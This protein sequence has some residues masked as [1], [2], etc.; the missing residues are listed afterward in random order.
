[1]IDLNK[2]GDFFILDLANNHQGDLDHA[3]KIIDAFGKK[4]ESFEI[5]ATIKLQFRNL[6]SYIHKSINSSSSDNS[7]VKRF[8]STKLNKSDYSKIINKIKSYNLKTMSTPFDEDSFSLINELDID[9]IKI[10]SASANDKSLLLETKK[11]NKPCVISVGGK[12]IE[13]ID[14]IVN[15]FENYTSNFILQHC[16]AVYPT[17]DEDLELNQISFLKNRYP[18]IKIGYSTHEDPNNLDPIK[19]A[20]S[21]G[22]RSFERHIGIETD[23]YKLNG[24]S[25]NLKQFE[26]WIISYQDAKK[27]L[28]ASNKKPISNKENETLDSLSRGVYAKQDIENQNILTSKNTYFSFPL[29][30]KQLS[31]NNFEDFKFITSKIIKKDEPILIDRIK[32]NID[33]ENEIKIKS[34]MLQF[35]SMLKKSKTYINKDA[36]IELSHHYG[37]DKFREF[38][39]LIITCFNYDYAKKLILLL[40]RQKHPYHFHKKKEETF[41][42]LYGDLEAEIDGDPLKLSNGDICTVEVNKWHK[43]QTSKG[44]IFEEIS[45]RHYNDD[46]F[47]KDSKIVNIDRS[48]RKTSLKNWE[49]FFKKIS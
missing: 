17:P 30:E 4:I 19:L 39:C 15:F 3:L 32:E 16:V 20:Y 34:I 8:Q 44:V 40:P 10:A 35:K 25:S 23:K 5:E 46:S 31:S 6:E 14:E 22:A 29:K 36:E 49:N 47:Y 9:I 43:F 24:Y 11:T 13:Q 27:L 12:D 21:L 48:E 18:N 26:K 1:M 37:L 45:T 42:I 28:G 7:Y 38:G 33:Y 2:L 41:Q